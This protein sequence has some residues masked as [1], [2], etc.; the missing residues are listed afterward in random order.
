[1]PD[2]IIQI[3]GVLT[4]AEMI[5]LRNTLKPCF[6]SLPQEIKDRLSINV[7]RTDRETEL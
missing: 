2:I 5:T 7:E 3:R 1:M 4:V 6:V